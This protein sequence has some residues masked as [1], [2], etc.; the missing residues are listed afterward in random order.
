VCCIDRIAR[1]PLRELGCCKIEAGIGNCR[2]II[3]GART[4]QRCAKLCRCLARFFLIKGD[5]AGMV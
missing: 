4:S 3:A 5:V 2:S 1:P